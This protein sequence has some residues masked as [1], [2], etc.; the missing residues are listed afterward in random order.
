MY[1]GYHQ[2]CFRL[3]SLLFTFAQELFKDIK[4]ICKIWIEANLKEIEKIKD[5][6]ITQIR[7]IYAENHTLQAKVDSINEMLDEQK[8][9]VF[10]ANR[11]Y[12][13]KVKIHFSKKIDELN[14]I[15]EKNG[16][17]VK[18]NEQKLQVCSSF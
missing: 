16:K 12:F 6:V 15:N 7:G 17:K 18:E 5:F 10:K 11:I 9:V 4:V 3:F 14:E 8:K 1:Q 2:S 13:L